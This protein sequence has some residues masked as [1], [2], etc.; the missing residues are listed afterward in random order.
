[1]W[2]DDRGW[3]VADGVG[4]PEHGVD[5]EVD[6]VGRPRDAHHGDCARHG[7]LEQPGDGLDQSLRNLSFN[8]LLFHS[9][10]SLRVRAQCI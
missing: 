1:M 2:R 6:K 4:D 8:G 10:L 7:V 3:F 5:G 9:L